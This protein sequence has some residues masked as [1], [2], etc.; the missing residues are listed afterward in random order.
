M[1]HK[2]LSGCVQTRLAELEAECLSHTLALRRAEQQSASDKGMMCSLAQTCAKLR[3][4]VRR[5]ES[6]KLPWALRVVAVE[7]PSTTVV[8]TCTASAGLVS[9]VGVWCA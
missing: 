4:Q 2:V 3:A 7:R 8:G 6:Q 5:T 9:L 1:A